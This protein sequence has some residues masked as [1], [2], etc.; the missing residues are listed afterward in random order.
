[1]STRASAW[2][3]AAQRQMHSHLVAVEVGVERARRPAGA[4]GW[5]YPRSS[6]GLEGLDAETVQRRCT[7]QQHGVLDD[8]FFE[9]VPHVGVR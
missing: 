9:D 8:D 5:P 3:S 2:A 7:V 4:A 6:C 1:M